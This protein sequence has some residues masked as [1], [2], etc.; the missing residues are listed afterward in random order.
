MISAARAVITATDPDQLTAL[1]EF[2]H[3]YQP[4]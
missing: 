3:G 1:T 4:R 2:V